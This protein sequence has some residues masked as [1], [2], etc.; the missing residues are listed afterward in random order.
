MKIVFGSV[1][2]IGA[3]MACSGPVCGATI[4]TFGAGSAVTSIDRSAV[5]DPLAVNG[6]PL[7][8]YTE[9]GLFIGVDGDSWI[10]D[11]YPTVFD[12]FHIPNLPYGPF[13]FPYGGSPGWVTIQTTDGRPI[14]ALEFLYGNGWTTGDPYGQYPWGNDAATVEWESWSGGVLV[15]SGTIGGSPV[16]EMGTVLGFYDTAGFDQLLVKC[17]IAGSIPP[18]YQALALDN[19]D[20][21]TTP[22]G[23]CCLSDGTCATYT[24]GGCAAHGG[25]YRGDW[26]SCV[27]D[28]CPASSVDGASGV[29]SRLQLDAAPNPARGR[30]V[31]RYQ[32]PMPSAVTLEVF[33]AS[34][35]LVR[36]FSEGSRPAGYYSVG[37]DARDD[38]GRELPAGVYLARVTT[39]G[40]SVTGRLVLLTK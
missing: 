32:L 13:Y 6:I 34:G 19:L 21:Q 26:T 16:L 9:G 2:M 22:T 27:P 7:S 12:P 33:A 39:T 38:A 1:I 29:P 10:G 28:L 20:V 8:D 14:F 25:F 36:R 11:G 17:T 4:Q 35:S 31:L 15:S 5:F 40:G 3:C 23:A 24:S 37:W 30:V 18:D